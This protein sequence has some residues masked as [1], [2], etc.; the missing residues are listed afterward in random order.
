MAATHPVADHHHDHDDHHAH[1]QGFIERW[2]FSTNH[3]DIGTLYL[4][5]SFVMFIIG[6]GMSVIIR[7][8]LAEPG[9][10]FVKP[11]FFNQMTTM[12]ALVMIFGGV[13][14]AFVGLANWMIPLQIGAPDMALPRMNNWSFWILPFAFTL[15]L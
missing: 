13:M 6:A 14:P 7:A 3:K 2:F 9:L 8:E 11:E 1:Q 5:F 10:Q 15:L 4:I 12:H